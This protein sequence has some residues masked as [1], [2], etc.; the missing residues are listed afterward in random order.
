MTRKMKYL[1]HQT[2]W[3]IW[4]IQ[5]L[6]KSDDVIEDATACFLSYQGCV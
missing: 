3:P 5:G 2:F 4:L 6:I 1:R